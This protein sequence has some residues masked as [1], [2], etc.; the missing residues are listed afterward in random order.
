MLGGGQR[1]RAPLP[2]LDRTSPGWVGWQ[3]AQAEH[4]WAVYVGLSM[5]DVIWT[6][7]IV[8]AACLKS[9][10]PGRVASVRAR[11]WLWCGICY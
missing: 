9:L 11:H 3:A 5:L 10:L 6:G 8:A 1:S 4:H 7:W 2:I